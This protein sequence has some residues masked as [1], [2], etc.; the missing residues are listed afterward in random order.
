MAGT[1]VRRRLIWQVAH[2]S[3]VTRETDSVRTIEPEVPD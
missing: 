1:A 2:V 3:S